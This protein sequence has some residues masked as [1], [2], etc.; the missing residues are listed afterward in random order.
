[1]TLVSDGHVPDE[2]YAQA[3]QHFS[4]EELGN[5]AMAVVAIN[6]C[7]RLAISFCWPAGSYQPKRS[8]LT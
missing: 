7:N 8:S 4:E 5:L 3:R 6:G 1:V 2:V